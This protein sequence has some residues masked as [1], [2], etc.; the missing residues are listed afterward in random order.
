VIED[1]YLWLGL[2][3]TRAYREWHLLAQLRALDLPVPQPLAARIV[4]YGWLYR[5]DIITRFLPETRPLSAL[6]KD[7]QDAAV[8]W[9]SIG[10]MLARFHREG[11]CHPDLTAHNILLDARRTP[12]LVD[13]D[14]CRFRPPGAWRD[15]GIRRLQRSLRKVALE[16]G[17]RFDHSGWDALESAY[18][19]HSDTADRMA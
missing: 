15:A 9:A 5:S 4:R 19:N 12:F 7:E 8:D 1:H 11:V 17:T 13:F 14:N 10:K 6:L 18:R 3:R 16:S 2:K